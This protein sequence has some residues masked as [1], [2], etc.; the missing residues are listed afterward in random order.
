MFGVV[1]WSDCTEHRAVIWC[2]DHGELAYF[3]AVEHPGAIALSMEPGDLVRFDIRQAG[4]MRLV[5]NPSLVAERQFPTLA[6]DLKELAPAPAPVVAETAKA[7]EVPAPTTAII[8]PF[9]SEVR[10]RASEPEP[11]EQRLTV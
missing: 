11:A 7:P 10:R 6:S 5:R 4:R 3:D 2:E 1:L 9:V 8:I